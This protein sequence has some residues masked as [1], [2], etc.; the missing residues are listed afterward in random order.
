[1]GGPAESLIFDYNSTP[2]PTNSTSN[3]VRLRNFSNIILS[4]ITFQ[5][6]ENQCT[7]VVTL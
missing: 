2:T 3:R 7:D 4:L 5:T 1:M 6:L